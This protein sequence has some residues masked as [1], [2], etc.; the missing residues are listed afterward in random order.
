MIMSNIDSAP[1][2]SIRD[3][4]D[5]GLRR[6]VEEAR[7]QLREARRKRAPLLWETWRNLVSVPN[8]DV[9]VLFID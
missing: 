3:L 4:S 1:R 8:R 5:E 9:R 6:M 2:K 7:P